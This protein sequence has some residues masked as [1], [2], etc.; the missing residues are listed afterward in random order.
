[1]LFRSQ[2]G[3]MRRTQRK[4]PPIARQGI[5]LLAKFRQ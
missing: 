4:R 2:R 5:G 3:R 1:V